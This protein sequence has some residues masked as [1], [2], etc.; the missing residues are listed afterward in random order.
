MY[1]KK[2]FSQGLYDRLYKEHL[3]FLNPH[4]K[5]IAWNSDS[6][7]LKRRF[8]YVLHLQDIRK[9]TIVCNK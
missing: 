5:I 9:L 4:S 7:V 3:D 2:Y 6:S 1:D 8:N